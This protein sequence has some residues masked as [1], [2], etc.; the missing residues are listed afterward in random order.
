MKIVCV[1]F[2]SPQVGSMGMLHNQ[3]TRKN[4]FTAIAKYEV[5]IPISQGTIGP[6]V[7][8]PS[9]HKL[10]HGVVQYIKCKV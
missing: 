10:F 3:Y 2:N 6:N 1:K 8:K 7:K 5:D 9:F 4:F